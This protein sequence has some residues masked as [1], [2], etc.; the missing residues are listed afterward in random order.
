MLSSG[1]TLNQSNKGIAGSLQQAQ[2][3]GR[4]TAPREPSLNDKA[5]EV[6]KWVGELE[7][8]MDEIVSSTFIPYVSPKTVDGN[9]AERATEPSLEEKIHFA[10]TRLASL[11]GLVATMQRKL[12]G[13]E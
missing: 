3:Y 2:Q 11:C 8:R 9:N 12:T 13:Q 4:D 10:S 1:N 6:L 7:R 5:S